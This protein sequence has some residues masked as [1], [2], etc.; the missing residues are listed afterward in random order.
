MPVRQSAEM[1]T[2]IENTGLKGVSPAVPPRT[3]SPIQR[4][5]QISVTSTTAS[6]G[7][8]RRITNRSRI[9]T[10][11]VMFDSNVGGRVDGENKN[12]G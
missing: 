6:S 12:G 2:E 5:A 11:P 4:D 10:I 8:T 1:Q 7:T 3:V 9:V